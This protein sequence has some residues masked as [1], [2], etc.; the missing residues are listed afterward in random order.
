M[1]EENLT[2]ETNKLDHRFAAYVFMAVVFCWVLCQLMVGGVAESNGVDL[3]KFWES[4]VFTIIQYGLFFG[5]FFIMCR[6]LRVGGREIPRAVGLSGGISARN[7]G[8][9]VLLACL[10][11]VSYVLVVQGFGDVLAY[12]GF[13]ARAGAGPQGIAQ[14]IAAVFGLCLLPAVI[15]ELLF[16]GFVLRGFLPLGRGAAVVASA[17]LFTFF[18]FNP[19]QT[20]YQFA[21]GIVLALVVLKTGNLVYAM[22]FHFLNNFFIVTTYTFFGDPAV[23]LVWSP[24][25]VFVAVSLAVLGSIMILGASKALKREGDYGR[26]RSAVRFFSFD[27]IGFFVA[28]GLGFCIWTLGFFG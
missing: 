27:N 26:A 24:L 2:F 28:T 12:L 3:D 22:I 6:Q 18:H 20:V 19:E 23:G 5:V 13:R 11:L 21:L 17:L 1:P 8:L 9:V 15:E 10:A 7:V 4:F 14:Y 25:S 16:R